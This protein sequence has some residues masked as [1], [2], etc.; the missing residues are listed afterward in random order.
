MAQN[1]DK[2]QNTAQVAADDKITAKQ[3]LDENGKLKPGYGFRYEPER[4]STGERRAH[5]V[6]FKVGSK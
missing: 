3:A 2:P 1:D 5:K 6:F 4:T